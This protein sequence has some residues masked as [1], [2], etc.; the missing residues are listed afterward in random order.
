MHRAVLR[1]GA[2]LL[3]P[4]LP[5]SSVG[6]P[7]QKPTVSSFV[8]W[9][10]Q[11]DGSVVEMEGTSVLLPLEAF[12]VATLAISTTAR[13]RA[14]PLLRPT[15]VAL[16]P[17]QS[18]AGTGHVNRKAIHQLQLIKC[19]YGGSGDGPGVRHAYVLRSDFRVCSHV[20]VNYNYV[21]V[22]YTAKWVE[23]RC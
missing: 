7:P 11:T 22:S 20:F 13:L 9:L 5:R 1:P 2:S 8:S 12:E 17:H 16:P 15:P 18:H 4:P 21:S 6:S 10:H 14:H 3:P 23:A 19:H